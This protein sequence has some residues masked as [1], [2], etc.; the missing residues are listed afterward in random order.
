MFYCTNGKG[1]DLSGYIG[2]EIKDVVL[3][4]GEDNSYLRIV[5]TDYTAIRI[6]DGGQQCCEYRYMT[7]DDNLDNLDGTLT[8]VLEKKGPF[9][10][11]GDD[12]CHETCFIEIRTSKG[13]ITLTTHNEHNGYYGGFELTIVEETL[14]RPPVVQQPRGRRLLDI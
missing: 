2:K 9:E 10:A 5:F 12:A 7:C 13:F 11:E 1:S 4:L 14:P 3:S 8:E 6:F